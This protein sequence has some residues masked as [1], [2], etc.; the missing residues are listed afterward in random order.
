MHR[1]KVVQTLLYIRESGT[2][3][4]GKEK[5]RRIKE[6][7]KTGK[8]SHGKDK[9]CRMAGFQIALLMEYLDAIFQHVIADDDVSHFL[10]SFFLFFLHVFSLN[11][12]LS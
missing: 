7:I 5:K 3:P 2:F 1:D 12:Y 8:N 6:I 10:F 11:G 9:K 4:L